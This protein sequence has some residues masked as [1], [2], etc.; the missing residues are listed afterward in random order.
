MVVDEPVSPSKREVSEA[1]YAAAEAVAAKIRLEVTKVVG[2]IS[3]SAEYP[4]RVYDFQKYI[5]D[6]CAQYSLTA[7]DREQAVAALLFDC[8]APADARPLRDLLAAPR[9]K[10]ILQSLTSKPES[11]FPAGLAG[12]SETVLASFKRAAER[13]LLFEGLWKHCY[14]NPSAFLEMLAWVSSDSE[15]LPEDQPR[16]LAGLRHATKVMRSDKNISDGQFLLLRRAGTVVFELV[17]LRWGVNSKSLSEFYRVS[18]QFLETASF[19]SLETRRAIVEQALRD[20]PELVALRQKVNSINE[21][22][23]KDFCKLNSE[24]SAMLKVAYDDYVR[25]GTSEEGP[26]SPGRGSVLSE[27]LQ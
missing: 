13:V 20:D 15:L 5:A 4:Q 26:A 11:V 10:Q 12:L 6:F 16:I 7:I 3:L 9:G 8:N 1:E 19:Y 21:L 23:L 14:K 17:R 2:H 18:E 27:M 25:Y 22:K 24:N